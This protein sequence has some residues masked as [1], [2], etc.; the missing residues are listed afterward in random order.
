M[1]FR[2]PVRNLRLRYCLLPTACCLLLSPACNSDYVQKPRTYP[3]IDFPEH[4]YTTFDTSF[5]PCTFEYPIYGSVEQS[6]YFFREEPEHPC[7]LNVSVP[8]LNA[9]IHLSYKDLREKYSLAKLLEDA[10]RLTYKHA[11]R[12]DY[13]E[14][15]RIVTPNDVQGVIY[16][17]GGDAASAFQFFLTDTVSH[18]LRG[19]LYINAEPNIDSLRPVISF[20]MVDAMRLIE[21]LKWKE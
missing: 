11:Q 13:I 9:T 10:H 21:T 14:P 12:A 7:W 16:S 8:Q 17:V 1:L 2:F 18:F 3:R 15:Q 20:L 6:H 5:C 4:A 19:S